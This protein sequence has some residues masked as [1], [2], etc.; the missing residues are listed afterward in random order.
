MK[1][2]VTAAPLI[3][4]LNP[5]LAAGRIL[6]EM[7]HEVVGYT[8]STLRRNV[9]ANGLRFHPYPPEADI[10][11]SDLDRIFPERRTLTPGFPAR[12]LAWE[13]VF[14][15]RM[16]IEYRG[17]LELL[18]EFP[19]DLILAESMTYSTLPLLMGPRA[20][21]PAIVHV[22]VVFLQL[23]RDDR[24]PMLSGLP[25]ATTP[26]EHSAYARL[27]EQAKAEWFDPI[28][29]IIDG[30]LAAHDR[31]P[32]PMPFHDAMIHLPDLFLQAGVPGLEFPRRAMPQSLH[33]IGANPPAPGLYPVPDWP[34]DLDDGR[35]VVLVTQ[36]TVANSNL[37]RLIGPTLKALAGEPDLIVVATT[38]GRPVEA[39]GPLPENARVA[40]YL[41]YDW[42]M[43]KVDLLV[44]NG[45]YGTV[46]QALS[47][48]IPL[49][50]AGTTEDK[51]EVAVRIA[52]SGAGVALGTDEP[53]P[54]QIRA[55]VRR[56]LDIPSYGNKAEA[57]A[58]EFQAHDLRRQIAPLLERLI[59][60]ARGVRHLKIAS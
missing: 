47:L 38:G 15:E 56:V 10:D 6:A 7:G 32:L 3:G 41:P 50:Q 39:L 42:L 37:E 43:P 23:S 16:D 34:G 40:E 49:V 9:E 52:C 29:R 30:V 19:A 28:D 1:I 57:L 51:R 45:G 25:P 12:K 8:P 20:D 2:I 59:P 36:G 4:H 24:A 60:P 27:A 18:R 44:T 13:R 5:L 55:A 11:A 46:T 17:L 14:V 35:K 48:G 31:P 22:G 58:R 26:A 54:F 53:T 21:R 33:Y